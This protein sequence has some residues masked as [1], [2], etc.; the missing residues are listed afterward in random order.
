MQK[1][2]TT[3]SF[4]GIG[5]GAIALLIAIVHFWA[6]PFNVKPTIEQSLTE[7]AIALKDKAQAAIKGEHYSEPK[8]SQKYDVD[9]IL[10]V[11]AALLGGIAIIL[12]VVGFARKEELQAAIAAVGLGAGAIAFQYILIGIGVAIAIFIVFSLIFNFDLFS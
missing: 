10:V 4:T 5:I 3:L 9:K 11:S 1:E 6:G 8:I 7:K 12:G 2:K